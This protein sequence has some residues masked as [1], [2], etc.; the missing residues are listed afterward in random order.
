MEPT[1]A[2]VQALHFLQSVDTPTV[3][4]AI[5]LFGIRPN[6][7]GFAPGEIRCLF[8]ELGRMCGYAV[9]AQVETMTEGQEANEAA[10]LDLFQAVADSPK[11]AVVVF[12]EIGP[13]KDFATHAGEVMATLFSQ[14]GAVGLV[15]DCAVRDIS[16]V[17]ALK[18]H[19][20]ARGMVASHANFHIVRVNVPVQVSGLVVQPNWLLHGDENGLI[21]VPRETF[22]GLREAVEKIRTRER[23]LMEY[24]RGP[25]F[26]VRGLRGR[27]R[28][29]G[30]DGSSSVPKG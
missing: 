27:F 14:L 15:S 8:P 5:E 11:P 21:V 25:E 23:A 13:R 4:N 2:E 16:E 6:G 29:G 7:E 26:T 1:E 12:Q 9:T 18:F 19:C 30:K 20:F 10:F 17:R 22:P 24:V 28:E 3:S